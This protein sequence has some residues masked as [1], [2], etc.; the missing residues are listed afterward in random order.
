MSIPD[1]F[2]FSKER[3]FPEM[4]A[5]TDLL[6]TEASSV[7]LE[8]MACG[9]PVIIMEN[10]EG[11][12]F[13]PVPKGTP[14]HLYA[15]ANTQEQLIDGI[16]GFAALTLEAQER[17]KVDGSKIR[18]DYFEPITKEGVDRIMGKGSPQ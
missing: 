9:V 13:D 11:L 18:D 15:R 4:L 14:S 1:A 8:A 10:D 17:L 5:R 3:S 12:M 2:L 7:C 16:N 6:I